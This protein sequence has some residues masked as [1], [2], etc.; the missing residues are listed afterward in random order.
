[1]QN[2][3][4]NSDEYPHTMTKKSGRTYIERKI[5]KLTIALL[6]LLALSS[7]FGDSISADNIER[8]NQQRNQYNSYQESLKDAIIPSLSNQ[9]TNEI[10]QDSQENQASQQVEREQVEGEERREEQIEAQ[11]DGQ[12]QDTLQYSQK[13]NPTC[14]WVDYIALTSPF[15]K[16]KVQKEFGFLQPIFDSYSHRCLEPSDIA[17]LLNALKHKAIKKGYITT[18]FGLKP[19]NLSTKR[20]LITLQ[21]STISDITI[22]NPKYARLLRK[23]YGIKIGDF[24]NITAIER[25]LYNYKRLRSVSPRIHLESHLKSNLQ[26]SS[27]SSS[28]PN[29][30]S[31]LESNTKSNPQTPQSTQAA[32]SSKNTTQA[33]Q[34]PQTKIHL[35]HQAK[36]LGKI[37]AP[38]YGAISIDNAGSRATNIYQTSL[39]FGLENLAGLAEKLSVYFVSTPLWDKQKSSIYTSL[40]FSMPIRRVLLSASGSYAWYAQSIDIAKNTLSY[41]GYL[42]NIDIKAQVLVFMNVNHRLSLS[43]GLGKRWAKN[44]LEKIEL[45]TQRRNLSNIYA[46]VHYLRSFRQASFDISIG[47]KQ[48]IKA[49]GAMDNF[50]T[51]SND[52]K[53]N[54]FYTI[55][56]I[57]AFAYIPFG[58]ENHRFVYTGFVKTQV[59]RTQLYASEKLSLGGI[60]SVRGFDSLVLSGEVGVLYRN[61][62][63]YYAKSV[64]G[65]RF[66]P[67][68]GLDMGYSLNLYEKPTLDKLL[69]GGGVGLKLYVSKYFNAE[70]WGYIPLYNPSKLDK[71]HF[72]FSVG[73]M[74]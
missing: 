31:S 21:T 20:L 27:Q 63:S 15:P 73:S 37:Y 11:A 28:Q 16:Q 7:A 18:S 69:A 40:D 52:S 23:D 22:D 54:F 46:G 71:R 59:S 57:D 41:N 17:T 62:F 29:L 24:L 64:Y 32:Q 58:S 43:L 34:I 48:G 45:I 19:Q 50:P 42:A 53:P 61:D 6:I 51:T 56:T 68:I 2:H 72:Y 47:I 39:Q 5:S 55:P 1:M 70:V 49:L 74:F 65:V 4:I 66:V 33:L 3:T 9:K 60:Y 13:S 44:Y 35:H 10:S 26:S 8:L 14:F 30:Q 36:T 38:F 12:S 25:G 67:S